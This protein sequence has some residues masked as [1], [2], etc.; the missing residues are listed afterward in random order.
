MG[1]VLKFSFWIY[2]LV[3]MY[4]AFTP[5]TLTQSHDKIYHFFAFFIFVILLKEAYNTS[6]WGT[7]FYSLFFSLFIEAV[8]YLL[9]Y[10][11]AEYGDITA[12]LLG[13]TSGLFMYFVIKLTY[14]ELKYKE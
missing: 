13:A 7:F 4:F 5:Q 9:P 10:R 8:Q 11:T 12:D 14:L 6:Y 3:I 2:T 1:K